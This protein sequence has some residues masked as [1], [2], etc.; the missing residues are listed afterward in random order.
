MHPSFRL[1]VIVAAVAVVAFVLYRIP[2]GSTPAPVAAA[3]SDPL[4]A[5][6]LDAINDG[7]R[8]LQFAIFAEDVETV[9]ELGHPRWIKAI[10]GREA[11]RRELESLGSRKLEAAELIEFE[12]TR[13]PDEPTM[14]R[15]A[16]HEFV[17]VSSLCV[18][19]KPGE[20]FEV[21]TFDLAVRRLGTLRWW[22]IGGTELNERDA[23][24]LFPD[25]PADYRFPSKSVR[26]VGR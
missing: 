18:F 9:L 13:F 22:Y 10:G 19:K 24:V 16:D 12:E 6:E 1:W 4:P 21:P 7:V 26:T 17:V 23:A 20:R 2:V 25:F 11:V 5:A 8:R 15:G 3:P 14:L